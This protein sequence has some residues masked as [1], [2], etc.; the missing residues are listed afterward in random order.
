M[1]RARRLTTLAHLA[2]YESERMPSPIRQAR[3]L[4][5]LRRLLAAGSALLVLLLVAASASPALHARLHAD[6]HATGGDHTCAVVLFSSGLALATTATPVIPPPR[7]WSACA[8][9]TP[10]ELLLD[11]PRYLRQPERGPPLC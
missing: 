1:K 5:L 4:P 2:S 11:S 3:P 10:D 8:L 9:A 6:P 7:A